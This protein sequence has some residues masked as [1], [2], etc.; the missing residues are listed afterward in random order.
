MS[1][2]INTRHN[3]SQTIFMVFFSILLLSAAPETAVSGTLDTNNLPVWKKIDTQHTIIYY[4]CFKDLEEFNKKVNFSAPIKKSGLANSISDEID[5]LFKRSQQLLGMH[6]FVNKIK[7]K[8]F[9]NK[10]QLDD[11]YFRTYKK[12]ADARAWY[13]HERLTVFIQLNDLHKGML[14]HELAHAIIDHY[15]IIP[16]PEETAEILAGY[17]DIHLVESTNKSGNDKNKPDSAQ[18]Y[19]AK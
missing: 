6:G 18:G 1:M 15:M 9:K 8:I 2:N 10:Q 12:D 5:A 14:A 19:S 16:P 11:A 17:V 3:K 13:T 4:Q 7:V